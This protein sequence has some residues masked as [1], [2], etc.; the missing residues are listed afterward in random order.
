MSRSENV[1]IVDDDR[2][3]RWVLEKALQQEGMATQSFD[4]ADGVLARLARRLGLEP[5]VIASRAPGLLS[6]YARRAADEWLAAGGEVM[7]ADALE[8]APLPPPDLV[9]DAL[10]GTGVQLP[11]SSPMTKIVATIN[12]LNAPVLA[13]DLPSGL[14]ADT[15]RAMGAL[16]RATRTLTFIGIINVIGVFLKYLKVLTSTINVI[17]VYDV[18]ILDVLF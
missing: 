15:G 4:S 18:V 3:I 12:G 1:W 7:M 6:C 16:V 5:L 10:L 14:N 2:S 9:I 13:V 8:G 17:D 11:L